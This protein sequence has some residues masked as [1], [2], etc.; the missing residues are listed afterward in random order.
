MI[1][2]AFLSPPAEEDLS[3][4]WAYIALGGDAPDA[5]DRLLET[6]R[7]KCVALARTPGIGRLRE[8]LGP[9]IRSLAVGRYVIF[10]RAIPEGIE[11]ARVLAGERDI[12]AQFA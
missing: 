4:I 1:R 7:R 8:E 10:Y 9:G 6:V 5:A 3:D 11:V 2:R 12:P